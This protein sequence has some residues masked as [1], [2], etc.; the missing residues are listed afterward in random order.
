MSSQ[1]MVLLDS[2]TPEPMDVYNF[3]IDKS[4]SQDE[5][6]TQELNS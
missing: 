5:F 2:E 3:F 6:V 4:D 1:V